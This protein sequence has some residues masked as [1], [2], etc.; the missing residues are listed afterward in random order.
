MELEL[1]EGIH[2]IEVF[3]LPGLWETFVK[4]LKKINDSSRHKIKVQFVK[5]GDDICLFPL[6]I[7]DNQTENF[8]SWQDILLSNVQKKFINKLF[9]IH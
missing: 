1:T 5:V 3:V 8:I 4:A 2:E 6:S 7:Q 9:K